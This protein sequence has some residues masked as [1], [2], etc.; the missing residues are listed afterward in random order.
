MCTGDPMGPKPH[1]HA[2]VA[3]RRGAKPLLSTPL[4]CLHCWNVGSVEATGGRTDGLST[5]ADYQVWTA[6]DPS[7]LLLTDTHRHAKMMIGALG[8]LTLAFAPSPDA[9]IAAGSGDVTKASCDTDFINCE[10]NVHNDEARLHHVQLLKA[11]H[12]ILSGAA[13]NE[14][15]EG[16][17]QLASTKVFEASLDVPLVKNGQMNVLLAVQSMEGAE[18]VA[19]VQGNGLKTFK[20][21][22]VHFTQEGQ[23]I[24]LKAPLSESCPAIPSGLTLSEISYCSQQDHLLATIN[25]PLV[26]LKV[27][28]K[29]S[30]KKVEKKVW[31]KG[32]GEVSCT[33]TATCSITW[34]SQ[35]MSKITCDPPG[36]DPCCTDDG[37]KCAAGE[38]RCESSGSKGIVYCTPDDTV[39]CDYGSFN[40]EQAPKRC[41]SGYDHCD[42]DGKCAKTP[43]PPPSPFAPSSTG[44]NSCFAKDVTTACYLSSPTA[45]CE[46][47]LMADLV[48]GDLVLGREGA[49]TVI[50]VQHK[51]VDT[52]AE[53]LTFHTADGASVSMTPDHAIFV[54]GKLLAAAEA[55]T[56]ATLTNA[57]G[58][59]T[60]IK[61]MTKSKGAIINV[62][63]AD[64]TIV[65]DG[66]FA[67]SNPYWIASITIDA[68][69]LRALVN[70]VLYAVGDA[71]SI[72]AVVVKLAT[73]LAVGVLAAKAV[74]T[75]QASV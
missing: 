13:A 47:V 3:V 59:R 44:G 55:T 52:I 9:I 37:G 64:G 49:T 4:R 43:S 5:R 19:T 62:V 53:M 12:G 42:A 45:E 73:M 68:P 35:D 75:R 38:K 65:A 33:P 29:A 36:C 14:K 11:S 18:G 71:D 67:A 41:E 2:P 30:E 72:G 25:T 56:G 69:A 39:C 50:A 46:H 1:G 66:F 7:H 16:N 28:A 54:D 58:E 15:C 8:A 20:C 63:T 34:D 40:E 21:D 60:A 48:P 57:K 27:V 31:E 26:D 61:R 17:S 74:H 22:K 6:I 10:G 23:A 32:S 51:V 70:A 24:H